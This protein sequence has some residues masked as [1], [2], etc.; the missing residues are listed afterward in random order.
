MTPRALAVLV[1]VVIVNAGLGL[2]ALREAAGRPP[3]AE[4]PY[5]SLSEAAATGDAATVVRMVRSHADAN[6]MGT[7]RQG[8]LD[9]H[10]PLEVTPLEAAVLGRRAE[11]IA[12]LRAHGAVGES[13]AL[14]CL[15]E[16]IG[17]T[18]ALRSLGVPPVAHA[19]GEGLTGADVL[20]ECRGAVPA[21]GTPQERPA[22]P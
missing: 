22:P 11:L 8:L 18:D 2:F 15:A 21:S 10:Q 13:G 6:A 14:A 7:V 19:A 20:Q 16:A 9:I 5:A 4:P 3:F 17:A 12:L 1:P